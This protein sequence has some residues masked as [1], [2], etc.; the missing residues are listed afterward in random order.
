VSRLLTR[1]LLGC[2]LLISAMVAN[3]PGTAAQQDASDAAWATIRARVP[4]N[5]PL[6]R[7]TWLPDRFQKPGLAMTQGPSNNA[8]GYR[9]E[10][11]DA[12]GFVYERS[13]SCAPTETPVTEP[14]LIHGHTGSLITFQKECSPRIGVYWK[15]NERAY[16]IQAGPVADGGT[17][18]SREEMLHIVA[19]L[20]LVGPDGAALPQP[21]SSATPGATCFQE[22]GRCVAGPFLDRWRAN[23]GLARNG[24]PL[25]GEMLERLEDGNLYQVQY[26]ERVRMEYHQINTG[27]EALVLLGQFG[28]RILAD[29][30]D[31]PTAPVSPQPGYTH[32]AETGHNV[33]PRFLAY[34]QAN[35]GLAQFGYPLTELFEQR[36]ENGQT[37]QVQYFER[38]RFELHLENAAPYDVLLGQFGRRILSNS[39]SNVVV[40]P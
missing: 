16:S 30:P 39:P 1:L 15:I 10:Q 5:Q 33:G 29:L 17:L 2:T 27:P 38:A 21:A 25:T 19:G 7:P 6:Y 34:W 8:V 14:I 18:L 24:Y 35:G 32:F 20:A 13:N 26:F 28:R 36:L 40:A 12:I 37:Y 22:T 4:A 9:S 3:A 23:G 31:A 11:G